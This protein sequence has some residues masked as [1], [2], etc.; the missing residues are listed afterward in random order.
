MGDTKK[1]LFVSWEDIEK[2]CR[3]LYKKIKSKKFEP[4]IIIGVSRGGLIPI[5]VL[6]DFLN[7]DN[8]SVIRVKFY[9]R[10]GK[11]G[12]TSKTRKEPTIIENTTADIRNK[13]ILV[14]DDV[15]ESGR[16]LEIVKNNL[17]KR[18]PSKVLTSA[19]FYKRKSR[20]APDF[21]AKIT[22]KWIVFPW[23]RYEE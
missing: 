17:I 16:T 14:V 12:R 8:I 21:Y 3:I 10:S 22:D 1:A 20:P 4:D 11:R 13:K 2:L 18:G 19:L 9:E 5:R 23:E 6:S 15:V 7:N